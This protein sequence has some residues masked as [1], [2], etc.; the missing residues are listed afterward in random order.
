MA[1]NFHLVLNLYLIW[2]NN[3]GVAV[4][5]GCVI[6]VQIACLFALMLMTRAAGVPDARAIVILM[7]TIGPLSEELVRWSVYRG[8]ARS[9]GDRSRAVRRLWL[10]AGLAIGLEFIFTA[11]SM[12]SRGSMGGEVAVLTA[13]VVRTPAT[14]LHLGATLLVSW[15]ADRREQ[16][17]YSELAL[18]VGLSIMHGAANFIFLAAVGLSLK[19]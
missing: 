10:F 3:R 7:L 18:P 16:P 1:E 17:R 2:I 19:P 15:L 6:V 14:L 8:A 11:G 9:S 13:L 4:L 12:L 5:Y